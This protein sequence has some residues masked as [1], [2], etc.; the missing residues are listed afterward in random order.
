MAWDCFFKPKIWVYI[1]FQSSIQILLG[2]LTSNSLPKVF[3]MHQNYFWVHA[4]YLDICTYSRAKLGI[5][6]ILDYIPNIWVYTQYLVICSVLNLHVNWVYTEYLRLYPIF[7]Y[8]Y[9]SKLTLKLGTYPVLHAFFPFP[10]NSKK[11]NHACINAPKCVPQKSRV[12]CTF[13]L[14]DWKWA[15]LQ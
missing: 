8:M 13:C 15:V 2:S 1:L 5:Y 10:P 3:S 4:Q 6:K 14:Y 7:G 9:R 12:W 11:K